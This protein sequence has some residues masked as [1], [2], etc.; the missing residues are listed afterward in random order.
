MFELCI[1]GSITSGLTSPDTTSCR[2][3]QQDTLGYAT[4]RYLHR[5]H[6]PLYSDTVSLAAMEL[7]VFDEHGHSPSSSRSSSA[8]RA[9]KVRSLDRHYAH[10]G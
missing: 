3:S 8:S 6:R 9:L 1:A 7:L 10:P 2:L 5:Y 4:L